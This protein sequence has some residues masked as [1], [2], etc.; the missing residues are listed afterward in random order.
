MLIAVDNPIIGKRTINGRLYNRPVMEKLYN[1]FKELIKVN[2]CVVPFRKPIDYIRLD[3]IVGIIHD[4]VLTDRF[5]VNLELLPNMMEITGYKVSTSLL[6]ESLIKLHFCCYGDVSK[7]D[8]V[9]LN[10]V[11]AFC[12]YLDYEK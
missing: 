4:I 8:I 12:F 2:S 1:D 11:K 5:V 6:Q 7:K 10:S 3:T 9:K